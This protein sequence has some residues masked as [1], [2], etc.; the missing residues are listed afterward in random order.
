LF[1]YSPLLIIVLT[2]LIFGIITIQLYI[3][4]NYKKKI[5]STYENIRDKNEKRILTTLKESDKPSSTKKIKEKL[6]AESLYSIEGKLNFAE[7]AGLIRR[8]LVNKK[9]EPYLLWTTRF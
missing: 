2:I 6:K 7:K 3:N 1:Q 4:L 8:I 9:D 5:R